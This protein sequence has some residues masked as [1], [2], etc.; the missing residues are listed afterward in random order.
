VVRYQ[1]LNKPESA[2]STRS[3]NISYDGIFL[4]T[5]EHLPVGTRLFCEVFSEKGDIATRGVGLVRWIRVGESELMG[6][7]V[8][9]ISLY[10]TSRAWVRE[11]VDAHLAT[12][13]PQPAHAPD[14]G[15]QSR[16]SWTALT[17]VIL[18]AAL[19]L[20][21]VVVLTLRN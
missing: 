1:H 10:D 20:V 11:L 8:E 19:A 9:F 4:R 13:R 16:L 6:V 12:S 17:G 18:L 14:R 15:K 3:A 7:G 21:A 5:E 2:V